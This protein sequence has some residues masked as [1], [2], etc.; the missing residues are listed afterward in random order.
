MDSGSRRRCSCSG[1]PFPFF[2][3]FRSSLF[4]PLPLF[5]QSVFLSSVFFYVFLSSRFLSSVGSSSL[6]P[7]FFL[8][9]SFF[10]VSLLFPLFLFF[11]PLFFLRFSSVFPPFLLAFLASIYRGQGRCFLQLSWGS[12][13]LVGHW[14]RLP[15][16]GGWCAVVGRPLCPVCGLQAREWP[17]EMQIKASLSPSS[18]LRDRGKKM[19]SVVQN[20]TVLL[21]HFF[22][23]FLFLNV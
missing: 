4:L 5:S 20:D 22:L 16:F 23:F 3:M 15:R 9:F 8:F 12:S 21:F 19:N 11:F 6:S 2:S 18:P 13:R 7:L 10:P 17:A 14:A 1:R